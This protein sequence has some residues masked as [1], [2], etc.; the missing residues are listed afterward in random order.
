MLGRSVRKAELT[1]F[2]DVLG[3]QQVGCAEL[4]RESHPTNMFSWPRVPSM[5]EHPTYTEKKLSMPI[6]AITCP[7]HEWPEQGL[8]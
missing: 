5:S 1:K 7:D 3:V 6:V 2:T 8:G 4:E